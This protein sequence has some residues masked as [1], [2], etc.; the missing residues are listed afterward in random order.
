M[1]GSLSSI[2]ALKLAL[3][4]G[5]DVSMDDDRWYDI[6]VIAGVFKLFMRELPDQAIP[7]DILLELRNLTGMLM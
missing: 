2:N 7:P 1:P 6:N 3:D 4:N 5:E